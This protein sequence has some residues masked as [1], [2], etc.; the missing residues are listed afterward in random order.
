VA[1]F[2]LRDEPIINR[3]D[4]TH[5][6]KKSYDES[7][8]CIAWEYYD[9]DG[10]RCLTKDGYAK[11]TADYDERGNEVA[12][13]CFGL[14]DEPTIAQSD[15]THSVKKS[16]DESGNCIAW[17]YYD[18]NGKRCLTK[19][20]YAKTTA[21]YDKRGNEVAR[22]CFGL[23]DEPAI[24]Q[25]D[26]THAVKKSYDA[27]GNCIAWEYY[28]A[29]G[30]RCLTKNGYAK[31]TADYDERGNDVAWACFGL[32]DKPAVEQSY[33]Y[34]SVRKSYDKRGNRV[35]WEY[36][37]MDGRRCLV[38]DGYAKVTVNYDERGNQVTWACFGLR[39][40]PTIDQS[41]GTHAVK[42]SYDKRGN[43]IVAE[44]YS[45]DGQRCLTKGGY[46]KLK[47]GYDESGRRLEQVEFDVIGKSTVRKY[48]QRG[49][50]IEEAY[51]DETGNPTTNKNGVARQTVKYSE[52][53]NPADM[54]YFDR[55][56]KPIAVQVYVAE[57]LPG[58]Q[59]K[60]VGL[61][62]GDVLVS[63]DGKPVRKESE[64]PTWVDIPG[65]TLRELIILRSGR[66]ISFKIKPGKIGIRTDARAAPTVAK[67]HGGR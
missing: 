29:D 51:F 62:E 63:Y 59:A 9:V 25:S 16:Y 7:G 31:T 24:D 65:D 46:V 8:N 36:Y 2:G 47:A 39:D 57:V 17:E 35:A 14:R 30:Q 10:K 15:S 22:A 45:V 64:I 53:T 54:T 4:G 28:G 55:D 61:M 19:E 41:D 5:T 44:Y 23:H 37:G 18:V 52:G 58:G 67:M 40:E 12:W 56:G 1:F 21:D 48:D 34:H 27:R 13:A 32:D 60:E 38:K 6:V 43:C 33:G 42:K 26:G 20:G 66:R 3:V 49:E 50:E 11:T